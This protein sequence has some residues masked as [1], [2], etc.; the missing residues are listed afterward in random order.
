MLKLELA[1]QHL[2][3]GPIEER[4]TFGTLQVFADGRCFTE[5]VAPDTKELLAGPRVSGYHLAEWLA[6]NWWRLRWEA[7]P[8]ETMGRE[9]RFSHCLS[10]IGEGYVWPNIEIS[11]DGVKAIVTSTPTIDPAAG[12]YRYVGASAFAVIAATDLGAAIDGFVRSMLD[13]LDGAKADTNL[14]HIWRDLE[15]EQQDADATRLRRLEAR[16]GKG[17]MRWLRRAEALA[18][19]AGRACSP[20]NR[21]DVSCDIDE[22]AAHKRGYACAAALR[23]HLSPANGHEPITDLDELLARLGWAQRPSQTMELERESLLE[24]ALTRSDEGAAVAIIG[25][26]GQARNRFRL[27]RTAFLH[28]FTGN[29]TRRLVT[30]AHTWEQRA[31]RAFAAEFLA[32]AA[33]LSEQLGGRASPMVIDELADHYGVNSQTIRHQIANHRLAW[34]NDS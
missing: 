3:S 8:S 10:S 20:V 14:H 15:R 2:D 29:G 26:A 23:R 27:A 12:L 1:P 4:A 28:H 31:S 11:S 30:E 13:L 21:E 24:A 6:W 33:G 9:W 25:E 16:L 5:G 19:D 7:R 17:D 18:A 22:D 34:I 32:P